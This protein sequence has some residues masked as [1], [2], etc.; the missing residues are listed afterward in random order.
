MAINPGD[1]YAL[2]NAG[3]AEW[4][5]SEKLKV[6][7]KPKGFPS[8]KGIYRFPFQ[9]DREWRRRLRAFAQGA[10]RIREIPEPVISIAEGILS[11]TYNKRPPLIGPHQPPLLME[12]KG[13]K[14]PG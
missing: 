8:I 7:K 5:L 14:E 4:Y 3:V 1:M 12:E 9:P 13:L 10:K 2:F 11:G 6:E